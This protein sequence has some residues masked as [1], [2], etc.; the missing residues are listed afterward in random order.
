VKS[1]IRFGM[2]YDYVRKLVKESL[3][4]EGY[5]TYKDA[6]DCVTGAFWKADTFAGNGIADNANNTNEG[7]Y[8]EANITTGEYSLYK[9]IL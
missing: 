5:G 7:F 8:A 1:D 6:I 2:N 9:Q 4:D 3:E